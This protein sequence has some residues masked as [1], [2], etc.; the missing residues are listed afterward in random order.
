MTVLRVVI[1]VIQMTALMAYFL[2]YLHWHLVAGMLAAFLVSLF[3]PLVATGLAAYAAVKVWGWSLLL[4]LLVF[5]PG[6]VI[7]FTALAGA[8]M[9]GLLGAL[10]FRRVR[11]RGGFAR[12]PFATAAGQPD[13]ARPAHD[14]AIIEGE[15]LSSRVDNDPRP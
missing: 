4:A 12:G 2:D 6:L 11:A 14:D 5:L 1:V 13:P 10:L 9:A 7:T 8:G 15:V 3:L